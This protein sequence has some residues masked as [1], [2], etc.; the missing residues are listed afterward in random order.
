MMPK[1]ESKDGKASREKMSSR[2]KEE[3]RARKRQ[4]PNL[5]KYLYATRLDL[6]GDMYRRMACQEDRAKVEVINEINEKEK[7]KKLNRKGLMEKIRE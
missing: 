5:P 3:Y 6:K 1:N 4:Y 2:V 7:E